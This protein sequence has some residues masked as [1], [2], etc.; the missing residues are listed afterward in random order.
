[1][2][3]RR[4][5]WRR[6]GGFRDRVDRAR[7]HVEA[8][9]LGLAVHHG[10]EPPHLHDSSVGRLAAELEARVDGIGRVGGPDD[11]HLVSTELAGHQRDEAVEVGLHGQGPNY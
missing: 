3:R 4:A 9:L 7:E 2:G 8:T 1:V 10:L 5:R 6:G 11:S